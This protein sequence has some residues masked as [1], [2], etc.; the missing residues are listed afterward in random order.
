[1]EAK[2]YACPNCG[3]Y[4]EFDVGRNKMVCSYCGKE[5]T[6]F[7]LQD[8]YNKIN[9][10]D[11]NDDQNND[12]EPETEQTVEGNFQ[13]NDYSGN[14]KVYRC[15]NC[16]AE[17]MTD[18]YTSAAFC[19]FCG[20]PSLMEDRLT[21]ALMPKYVIPF[22]IEKEEAVK[23]Y[24]SWLG[25]GPLTPS[26][27]KSDATIDKITGMYV[28]FWLYDYNA[29]I[30]IS[31]RCTR[32]KR[33]TS[34]DYVIIDT[35]HYLVDRVLET[36]FE[37]V[38]ADASE[39]M[40]DDIM[41]KLEPFMYSDLRKFE[42]PYLSGYYSERFNYDGDQMAPRVE[43]RINMYSSN[44]GMDSIRRNGYS[45]VNVVNKNIKLQRRRANYALLPVWMLN[46]T[47]K[48]K[49]HMF[50]L[51][52]QTGKIVADRPLSNAKCAVWFSSITAVLFTILMLVGRFFGA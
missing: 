37:K 21:G 27:L 11:H 19:S 39:K 4:M 7:E 52:G 15:R 24:K 41:D 45:S 29:I 14:F 25:K 9:A 18:D 38:P 20:T 50:A 32:V 17:V 43:R 33:H 16:G 35:D 28:P 1:M 31:A 30:N 46:Y 34:G 22:K 8:Y 2:T 44:T 49:Q 10:Q 12:S 36:E 6:V 3:G 42:M 40:P 48:G 51:N 5:M 26:M 47:Y 23:R 13:Q